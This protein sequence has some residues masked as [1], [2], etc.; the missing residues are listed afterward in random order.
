MLLLRGHKQGEI[1]VSRMDQHVAGGVAQAVECLSGKQKALS[2]NLNTAQNDR[3]VFGGCL[4]V[5]YRIH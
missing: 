4:G 2:S 1:W 3:H 5:E